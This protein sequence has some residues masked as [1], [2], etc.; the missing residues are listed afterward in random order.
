M[1]SFRSL[2]GEPWSR[3]VAFMTLFE[4]FGSPW[5]PKVSQRCPEGSQRAPKSDRKESFFGAAR[6]VEDFQKTLKNGT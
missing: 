2:F 1:S 4:A 5:S 6:Y 3:W